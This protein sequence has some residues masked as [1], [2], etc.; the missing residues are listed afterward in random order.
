M[1]VTAVECAEIRSGFVRGQL[2]EGLAV[3]EHLRGCATCRELFEGGASLGR[4][5]SVGVVAPPQADQL[6][7]QVS[8]ELDAEVGVRAR[9][10]S[11][12][13]PTRVVAL[14]AMAVALAGYQLLMNRRADYTS[15]SPFAFWGIALLLLLALSAG[16][17]VLLRGVLAP[18]GATRSRWVV[19]LL[20]LVPLLVAVLAPLGVGAGEPGP[21]ATEWAGAGSC[22]SYG[23]AL[24]APVLLLLWLLDRR[25]ALPLSV[26][27]AAGGV[28]GL[29]ANL[30]LHVHCPSV[31]LA[32]LLLGHASIGAAWAVVL[33]LLLGRLQRG[34][35]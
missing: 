22:F 24:V 13:T 2:P 34:G 23:A 19:P 14:A 8:A 16:G 11:L 7:Q 20:L 35:S 4:A 26:L 25:D 27:I 18:L 5:L 10:R 28:A 6:L 1:T 17:W 33:G 3:A 15:Y 31:Q 32:H 30:L 29:A 21:D 12:P 9:V